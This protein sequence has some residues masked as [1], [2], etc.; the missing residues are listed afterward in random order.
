MI[1]NINW[2]DHLLVKALS[3][4]FIFGSFPHTSFLLAVLLFQ[5]LT[6]FVC[7][8]RMRYAIYVP[9]LKSNLYADL[10]IRSYIILGYSSSFK[11]MVFQLSNLTTR[12]K[13]GVLL[14]V[15]FCSVLFVGLLVLLTTSLLKNAKN[16]NGEFSH[17]FYKFIRVISG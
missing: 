7:R 17:I 13:H 2:I 6:K 9:C 10:L 11:T 4:M 16:A 14:A 3:M 1:Y 15:V 12:H 5:I 8:F